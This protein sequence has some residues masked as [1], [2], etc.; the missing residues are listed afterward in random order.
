VV[1]IRKESTSHLSQTQ[2]N[3]ALFRAPNDRTRISNA[4]RSERDAGRRRREA[5]DAASWHEETLR[6]LLRHKTDDKA[7]AGLAALLTELTAGY[8]LGWSDIAR[9]VG[10]SVPA[11]RKWRHGGD[12]S[13]ARMLSVAKLA[14]FLEMLSEEEISDPATWLN[15]PL[16]DV[17]DEVVPGLVT[18]KE[19][20]SSGG[21]VDLLEYA[22]KFIS[23]DEL[24]ARSCVRARSITSANRVITAADGYLSIVSDR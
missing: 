6:N 24:L 15:L 10:V 4:E 22:K 2:I 7:R 3:D 21:I 8:G 5:R 18:K 12:I 11:I 20:Y 13:S 19:I 23:H 14:A 1:Q 17:G 9:M 16:D